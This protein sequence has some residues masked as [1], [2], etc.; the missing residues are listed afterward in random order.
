M[1][2]QAF[3]GKNALYLCIIKL[4][5][6]FL[7]R[8]SFFFSKTDLTNRQTTSISKN[9]NTLV[10]ALLSKLKLSVVAIVVSSI[11]FPEAKLTEAVS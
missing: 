8:H 10:L 7:P 3:V 9:I 1:L 11:I 5:F 2:L 4:P 6:F